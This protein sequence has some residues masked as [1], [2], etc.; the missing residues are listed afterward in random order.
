[1][2]L[3]VWCMLMV[4]LLPWIRLAFLRWDIL[5]DSLVYKL[6][7]SIPTAAPFTEW[8]N[9]TTKSLASTTFP[10]PS[11]RRKTSWQAS[12]G[13][14]ENCILEAKGRHESC[15][16]EPQHTKKFLRKY[17]PS[18][19]C[20]GPPNKGKE[21]VL[22]WPLVAHFYKLSHKH[23]LLL[24]SDKVLFGCPRSTNI[25]LGFPLVIS[26]AASKHDLLWSDHSCI[27]YDRNECSKCKAAKNYN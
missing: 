14:H 12:R 10:S 24:Y 9:K 18:I 19:K 27:K 13:R 3:C 6:A 1:M 11:G 26:A 7:N 2:C 15:I 22:P 16:L 17:S 23:F 20:T 25:F 21:H 4:K 8:N 5:L